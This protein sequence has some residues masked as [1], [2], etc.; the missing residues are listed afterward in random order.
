MSSQNIISLISRRRFWSLGY[1]WYLF[2]KI[3]KI[4]LRMQKWLIMRRIC[5][6]IEI[7]HLQVH[8]CFL[9]FS[10]TI[11]LLMSIWINCISQLFFIFRQVQINYLK[12]FVF[13]TQPILLIF[14]FLFSFF[15]FHIFYIFN[16]FNI[17]LFYK[18]NYKSV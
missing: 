10:K 2:V 7:L 16:I 6:G 12:L 14:F 8:F 15:G 4:W 13:D 3:A 17:F 18:F 9:Y 5:W 1:F 11:F